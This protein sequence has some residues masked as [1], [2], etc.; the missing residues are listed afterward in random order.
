[1]QRI[2]FTQKTQKLL[3]QMQLGN[4]PSA[5]AKGLFPLTKFMAAYAAGS[6][7]WLYD[8]VMAGSLGLTWLCYRGWEGVRGYMD[9]MAYASQG[10]SSLPPE[11]RREALFVWEM[12]SRSEGLASAVAMGFCIGGGLLSSLQFMMTDGPAQPAS[13]TWMWNLLSGCAF[14]LGLQVAAGLAGHLTAPVTRAL[15]ESLSAK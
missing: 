2:P 10:F 14:L 6:A 8:P 13:A 15:Q 5:K 11:K 1:M 4:P 3:K 12:Q 9:C 7:A